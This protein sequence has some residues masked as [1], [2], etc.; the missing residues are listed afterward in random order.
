M[1][2]HHLS[3][4]FLYFE[5]FMLFICKMILYY[6]FSL[7]W[8]KRKILNR[9]SVG[10]TQ[11]LNYLCLGG[12]ELNNKH[13]SQLI[14]EIKEE[15]SCVI[16]FFVSY[17]E[18]NFHNYKWIKYQNYITIGLGLLVNGTINKTLR[19]PFF[20]SGVGLFKLNS[21]RNNRHHW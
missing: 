3:K 2:C 12:G 20:H 11:R 16:G 21:Y 1:T 7:F 17:L 19:S 9:R 14:I 6:T 5:W 4:N 15:L 8:M 18:N 13:T 10:F